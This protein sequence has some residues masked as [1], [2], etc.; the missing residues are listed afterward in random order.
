MAIAR[1]KTR[2][3]ILDIDGTIVGCTNQIL[4][5]GFTRDVL[6]LALHGQ[7]DGYYLC[8][9]RSME[10]Y[11]LNLLQYGEPPYRERVPDLLAV[12][13]ADEY[14]ERRERHEFLSG[15]IANITREFTAITKL[16]CYGISM[17]GD[18]KDGRLGQTYRYEA[19]GY[20]DNI[21][22][23]LRGDQISMSETSA[24]IFAECSRSALD[25][26]NDQ[27][28]QIIHDVRMNAKTRAVDFVI[29]DDLESICLNAIKL[30]E[31]GIL[32]ESEGLQVFYLDQAEKLVEVTSAPGIED[33]EAGCFGGCMRYIA[34][35][36]SPPRRVPVSNPN[37]SELI[38][39][40]EP[41]RL[42]LK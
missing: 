38:Q 41:L 10:K 37:P 6:R 5:H 8:T 25:S 28:K 22:S 20:E 27:Y 7:F 11:A 26:K 12:T 16:P 21:L 36:F 30:L 4:P 29:V 35:F 34:S 42:N 39:T 3:L 19:Q 1:S 13:F 14:I 33:D 32:R 9:H 40:C 23:S 17:L 24:K 15:F 2:V 18:V 31:S